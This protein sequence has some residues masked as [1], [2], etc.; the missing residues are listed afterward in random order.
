[1]KWL[2]HAYRLNERTLA[3]IAMKYATEDYKKK[4]GRPKL[5]WM[6]LVE[7]DFN[8]L[9]IKLEDVNILAQDKTVWRG[10]CE[11]CVLNP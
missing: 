2:G 7:K 9:G 6:K 10:I 5:T 11:R 1:M 3:S 4:R 8:E